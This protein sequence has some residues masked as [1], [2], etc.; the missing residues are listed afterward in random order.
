MVGLQI[1][2][3]PPNPPPCPT[4]VVKST[5]LE[6]FLKQRIGQTVV[7]AICWTT[8]LAETTVILGNHM[9]QHSPILS[10]LVV[11]DFPNRIRPTP[12]FF[13]G[14]FL[15]VIGGFIRYKCYK[16]MGK[17]FTFEMSILQDHRLVTSGPYSVVRHPGYT[18]ILCTVMGFIL[19]N[20]SSGSWARESGALMSKPGQL[21]FWT[22]IILV[23][24]I[25][26]GLLLRM[27]KED[28]ALHREFG[29]AWESW[30][31]AVPYKLFPG[32]Y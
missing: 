15:T 29:E 28:E 10:S 30:A 25:C 5:S 19:W 26:W 6:V 12:L 17:M 13:L 2:V 31:R 24:S 7:K 1:A 18:G 22:Y 21:L 20:L 3:T 8:A 27:V 9:H 14:T 23:A 16:E 11:E 32:I 4:S